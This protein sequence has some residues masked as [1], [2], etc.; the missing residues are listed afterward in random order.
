M[1][2]AKLKEHMKRSRLQPKGMEIK[3]KYHIGQT[4]S[5]LYL[6]KVLTA[7]VEE[8][9]IYVRIDKPVNILYKLKCEN[10]KI[11][12]LMYESELFESK[13]ALLSSL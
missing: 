1:E 11:T 2:K 13:Q 6:N 10:T 4:I 12:E 5:M 8:I 3:T 7:I 9:D